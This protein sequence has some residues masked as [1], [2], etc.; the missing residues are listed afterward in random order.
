MI[1]YYSLFLFVAFGV[2]L[3]LAAATIYLLFPADRRCSACDTETLLLRP[4]GPARG[5]ARLSGGR[6]Q[7]R[8]CPACGWEGWARGSRPRR[9]A[10]ATASGR[11]ASFRR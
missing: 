10:R 2:K 9:P 4:T 3:L 11:T 5:L 8:W 1:L 6:L 7:R